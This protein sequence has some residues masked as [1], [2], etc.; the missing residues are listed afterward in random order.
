MIAFTVYS[1]YIYNLNI[2]RNKYIN[3]Q[4][5]NRATEIEVIILPSYYTWNLNTWGSDGDFAFNFKAAYGIDKDMELIYVSK[6]E[7]S[8]DVDEIKSS[9][10][11]KG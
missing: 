8:V 10:K 4:L 5:E 7:A 11:L 9:S 1:F 6:D 2:D 3:Y